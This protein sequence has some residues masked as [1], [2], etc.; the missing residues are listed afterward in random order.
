LGKLLL[1]SLPLEVALALALRLPLALLVTLATISDS[2]VL[3]QCL[4]R[5]LYNILRFSLDLRI[6]GRFLDLLLRT[7]RR[8]MPIATASPALNLLLLVACF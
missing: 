4:L 2:G 5:L 3:L 6:S 7:S 8:R 1:F